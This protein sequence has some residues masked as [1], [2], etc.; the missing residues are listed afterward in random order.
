MEHFWDSFGLV[1]HLYYQ[2]KSSKWL[3]FFNGSALFLRKQQLATD[4]NRKQVLRH[5]FAEWQHWHRAEI[6]NRELAVT[7]EETRKKMNE[8]L[9]AASLGKLSANVSSSISPL[10]EATAMEDPPR[11]GEVSCF[12]FA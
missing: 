2:P 7:K 4:Y 11:N 12:S 1:F 9:K 8:L 3:L 6:Q 10:E 5:H